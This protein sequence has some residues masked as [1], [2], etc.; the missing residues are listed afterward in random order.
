MNM[1][2]YLDG[3]ITRLYKRMTELD[4]DSKEYEDVEEKYLKMVAQKLEIEKHEASVAQTEKQMKADRKDR[5][6]RNI[7]EGGRVVLPL[8]VTVMGTL[9][10]YTFEAKGVIPVSFGKKFVDKLTK[11]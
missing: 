4:P 9:L 3:E 6:W 10:A 8:G 1:N 11:Y 2:N 7:I 5:V